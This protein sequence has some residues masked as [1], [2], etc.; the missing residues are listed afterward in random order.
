MGLVTSDAWFEHARFASVLAHDLA[1]LSVFAVFF[2]LPVL[3]FVIGCHTGAV[4][5]G[6]FFDPSE[7]AGY[8]VVVKRMLAWFGGACFAGGFSSIA[9]TLLLRL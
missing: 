1:W 5:R 8:L 9:M 6:W 3:Y 7:R 4:S 2:F